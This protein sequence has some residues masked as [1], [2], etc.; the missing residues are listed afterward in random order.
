MSIG[1]AGPRTRSLCRALGLL[2]LLAGCA[3]R[4][5]LPVGIPDDAGSGAKVEPLID[6]REFRGDAP[7][8]VQRRWASRETEVEPELFAESSGGAAAADAPEGEGPRR[9]SAVASGAAPGGGTQA[10]APA[11]AGAA[12]GAPASSAGAGTAAGS[13]SP[14]IEPPP[15]GEA[16][17]AAVAYAGPRGNIRRADLMGFLDRSPASFLRNVTSEPRVEGGRFRGWTL[18]SFYPGDP[19]FVGIDLQQGDVITRIN[20]K[21]IEQPDQFILVWQELRSARELRVDLLRSGRPHVSRWAIS[22]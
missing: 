5:S 7:A 11:S 20:G 4:Q 14:L 22:D 6:E 15:A 9:G 19:R 16:A 2:S 1:N 10:V 8:P 21:P 17:P 3:G 13:Q 18:V 12:G